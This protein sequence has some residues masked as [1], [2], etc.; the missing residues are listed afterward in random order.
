MFQIYGT[1]EDL[2]VDGGEIKLYL[3]EAGCCEHGNEPYGSI[4]GM[5]NFLTS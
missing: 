5:W 3:R 4:K 2:D 1:L